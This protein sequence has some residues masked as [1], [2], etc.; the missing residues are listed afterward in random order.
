MLAAALMAAL[1]AVPAMAQ[2]V[3]FVMGN[4]GKAVQGLMADLLPERA[5]SELVAGLDL[6]AFN[7]TAA[8]GVRRRPLRL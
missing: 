1:T 2:P 5:A 3:A 6:E 7:W 4:T 8:V